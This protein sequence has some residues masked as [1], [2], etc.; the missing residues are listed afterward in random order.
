MRFILGWS[1]QA[2]PVAFS[3]AKLADQTI[4]VIFYARLSSL[5]GPVNKT[6]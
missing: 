3:G 4:P 1:K 6:D 2:Q 5:N